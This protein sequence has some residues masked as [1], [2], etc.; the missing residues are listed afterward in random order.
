MYP[1]AHSGISTHGLAVTALRLRVRPSSPTD[2]PPNFREFA[3]TS[4]LVD[5]SELA[6]LEEA[7]LT[8]AVESSAREIRLESDHARRAA[9]VLLLDFLAA[10]PVGPLD[11]EAKLE[12]VKQHL[13]MAASGVPA[14]SDATAES[15]KELPTVDSVCGVTQGGRMCMRPLSCQYH[16]VALKRQVEGRSRD[17]DELLAEFNA[18]PDRKAI[19]QRNLDERQRR[20]AQFSAACR[21]TM[22]NLGEAAMGLEFLPR[23]AL[24]QY[25]LAALSAQQDS[26]LS[27]V[28]LH[29]QPR[30]WSTARSAPRLV[31]VS[32]ACEGEVISL[33]PL[34][35]GSKPR[36][37][38]VGRST[39]CD[40]TLRNDDQISRTHMRL[41]VKDG[42]IYVADLRSTYGTEVNGKRIDPP[43]AQKLAFGDLLRLGEA[44]EF[45][46]RAGSSDAAVSTRLVVGGDERVATVEMMSLAMSG[47]IGRELAATRLYS[48]AGA[49]HAMR[50]HTVSLS[51]ATISEEQRFWARPIPEAVGSVP[52]QLAA[53]DA[54]AIDVAPALAAEGGV[55]KMTPLAE[56][57]PLSKGKVRY[58]IDRLPSV[59]A[60]SSSLSH[61][62]KAH[63]EELA[64]VTQLQDGQKCVFATVPVDSSALQEGRQVSDDPQAPTSKKLRGTE[65]AD[66]LLLSNLHSH[67]L[68]EDVRSR[69]TCDVCGSSGTHFRCG[70]G[71]DWDMC[72]RCYAQAVASRGGPMPFR[73]GD[74][75]EATTDGGS[76][77]WGG[78]PGTHLSFSAGHQFVVRQVSGLYF[79]STRYTTLWA[80]MSAFRNRNA[81]S[82]SARPGAGQQ[83]QLSGSGVAMASEPDH[84][85]SSQQLFEAL[86][87]LLVQSSHS[88][89]AQL[90]L[91]N[92]GDAVD[93]SDGERNGEGEHSDGGSDIR[94]LF[95]RAGPVS[96]DLHG[97]Q[98]AL[99][100]R[101]LL[102][103]GPE[104]TAK[105]V[106]ITT[107]QRG[108]Y[109][110]QLVQLACCLMLGEFPAGGME[111]PISS[112]I[113]AGKAGRD[114]LTLPSS[115]LSSPGTDSQ[116]STS[117]FR[118]GAW[119]FARVAFAR[120]EIDPWVTEPVPIPVEIFELLCARLARSA[121]LNAFVAPLKTSKDCRLA[122]RCMALLLTHAGTP[123]ATRALDGALQPFRLRIEQLIAPRIPPGMLKSVPLHCTAL[124]AQAAPLI[125]ALAKGDPQVSSAAPKEWE[126][127]GKAAVL[128][129]SMTSRSPLPQDVLN[130][131]RD[132][133]NAGSVTAG[134]VEEP[135][136]AEELE[137]SS[138]SLLRVMVHPE[139]DAS[140]VWSRHRVVGD[141]ATQQGGAWV[142]R[143][144]DQLLSE[145]TCHALRDDTDVAH[146]ALDATTQDGQLCRLVQAIAAGKAQHTG[147]DSVSPQDLT[148]DDFEQASRTL[149][150]T[151]SAFDQLRHKSPQALKGRAAVLAS[152]NAAVFTELLPWV[153]LSEGMSAGSLTR[154]IRELRPMLLDEPRRKHFEE[155]LS[156]SKARRSEGA[157]KHDVELDRFAA[158]RAAAARS[159]QPAAPEDDASADGPRGEHG[160][161]QGSTSASQ[162]TA[163]T[164]SA[165]AAGSGNSTID[166][167]VFEQLAEK[168]RRFGGSESECL[169]HLCH[170]DRA[171]GRVRFVGEAG[172]DEGGP[173]REILDQAV[174]ELQSS[175]LPLLMK[176]PNDKD[177]C[178]MLRPTT[179]TSET[180]WQLKV[181]GALIGVCLRTKHTL[182]FELAV[183]VWIGLLGHTPSLEEY[184]RVDKAAA[185]GIRHVRDLSHPDMLSLPK[186]I[187]KEI[188]FEVVYGSRYYDFT[189]PSSDKRATVELKPNGTAE[190]VTFA[191]RLEWAT[192]AEAF[193]V[194]ECDAHLAAMREGLA[195]IV[196]LEALA[197]FG[198][199]ELERLAAG[200]PRHKD[201][202]VADLR[203]GAQI[204]R[205]V[206]Q[207]VVDFFFEALQE[208]GVE[209][210]LEFCRF[211]YGR[212]RMPERCRGVKLVIQNLPLPSSS[213]NADPDQFLPHAHTCGFGIDLP[214]YT[215]KDALKAKLLYAIRNC[216][217]MSEA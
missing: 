196:P 60:S 9:F 13:R 42:D 186:E 138:W 177:G 36:G 88:L 16:S 217:D 69:N 118:L 111:R 159:S 191:N 79:T 157:R 203:R 89:A 19:E 112:L 124:Q 211:A 41:T 85:K 68:R 50:Q 165:A 55:F 94:S 207:Q 91:R 53:D 12:E 39:A 62:E 58:Y 152:L 26:G 136:A 133:A 11:E 213:R 65:D 14:A 198:P 77:Q 45:A 192:L 183:T 81:A 215:S 204:S 174:E 24:V 49:Y 43:N 54:A 208:F 193:L 52:H 63:E 119:L 143:A 149:L 76:C 21:P 108:E 134:P 114:L 197:F 141:S 38:V 172:V 93:V 161:V 182:P 151:T 17:L 148:L 29:L 18:S 25:V 200:D 70:H 51:D 46:F 2:V 105:L 180:L 121:K 160:A 98:A 103:T 189:L 116:A 130:A 92:E 162:A 4:K 146:A 171:L 125:T 35:D 140:D 110:N 71:C 82:A 199:D 164:G 97:K 64:A 33:H 167:T 113:A 127:V 212:S 32:G 83:G 153:D 216:K 214:P 57:S 72:N 66:P 156:A 59:P 188:G 158:A 132:A 15:A 168:I 173:Y 37:L 10:L 107:S 23:L 102:T 210:K 101:L 144:C 142:L 100:E 20:A 202:D 187:G 190:P 96:S 122:L 201:W 209:D 175:A 166:R 163:A 7:L 206:S 75:V 27:R 99:L 120:A 48:G 176:T 195:H 137:N 169:R 3:C 145:A 56:L 147:A 185:D 6:C 74:N 61:E 205:S 31:G 109:V 84:L 178:Y 95:E 40:A 106:G 139:A 1:F 117:L 181:L 47:Q 67:R 86:R 123:I 129:R 150:P 44:S 8:L 5:P 135:L 170:S 184:A 34:L 131:A 87:G 30:A 154:E 126:R 104:T 115:F 73:P 179:P 28:Q 22:R 194:H 128:M 90:L 78:C 80:P 155:L